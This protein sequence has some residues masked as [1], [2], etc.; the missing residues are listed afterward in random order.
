MQRML[1]VD[2]E[3]V[4]LDGLYAFFQKANLQ[5]ME[6]MKAYSAYEA[7]DWLNSVKVDIVLSDICMPGMDG[8][9]LIEQIMDRWPRCKVLLLTGHNEFDYAHQAIRN[10]W[11]LITC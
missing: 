2:D 11:L 7:I 5:D 6:I 8:M 3:P 4:I 10:P 9:Q 1:I